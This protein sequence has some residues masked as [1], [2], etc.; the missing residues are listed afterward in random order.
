MRHLL[1]SALCSLLVVFSFTPSNPSAEVVDPVNRAIDRGVVTLKKA[2]KGGQREENQTNSTARGYTRF[3]NGDLN[4]GVTALATLTLLEC[5]VPPDDPVIVKRLQ[6][7]R[8][9]SIKAVH[10]YTLALLILVFDRAGDADDVPLIHSMALRLLAGQYYADGWSYYCPAAAPEEA[11]KLSKLIK[12]R[13][14]EPRKK[15]EPG[16]KVPPLPEDVQQQLKQLLKMRRDVVPSKEN[17]QGR[18]D[19][20]NTQ[21]GVLGLWT[22]RRYGIPIGPALAAAESRFR[23]SQGPDG[24]WGY[25][26]SGRG[27]VNKD[28][29]TTPAMTCAAL[30]VLGMSY[31]H[32]AETALQAN[33]KAALPDLSRDPAVRAG[34]AYLAGGVGQPLGPRGR[35]MPKTQGYTQTGYYYLWSLERVGVGYNLRVIGN[36]DWYAWG[37]AILV[38]SQ[39]SDGFWQHEY[40]YVVDTCF[41]LLF[42]KRVNLFKDATEQLSKVEGLGTVGASPGD[43]K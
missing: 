32:T 14:A 37:A 33:P 42:L 4:V 1:A 6:S 31:A 17:F 22:A 43:K 11:K 3:A 40:G 24:G 41:A 2:L 26:P 12:D 18:G 19:N 16:E 25:V 5:G 35:I 20:S 8:E 27:E 30:M 13:P 7:L 15:M 23:K 10:T 34:F 21:F 36:K 39:E 9:A 28:T 29:G 38:A